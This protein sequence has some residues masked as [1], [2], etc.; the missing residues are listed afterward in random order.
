MPPDKGIY[1]GIFPST[2]W[3]VDWSGPVMDTVES[4]RRERLA[5]DRLSEQ[6]AWRD[7]RL[8]ALAAHK[9]WADKTIGD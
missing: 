3:R 5:A 1:S 6:Q 2:H 9:R 4:E 8:I 7:R